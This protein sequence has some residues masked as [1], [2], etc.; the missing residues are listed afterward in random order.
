[1]ILWSLQHN[2][3][4]LECCWM[5]CVPWAETLHLT[6][7]WQRWGGGGK[8]DICLVAKSLGIFF[9]KRHNSPKTTSRQSR[10][11]LSEL[12]PAVGRCSPKSSIHSRWIPSQAA[13]SRDEVMKSFG[14]RRTDQST[15]DMIIFLS[16]LSRKSHCPTSELLY[17]DN[18]TVRT[19]HVLLSFLYVVWSLIL[20]KAYSYLDCH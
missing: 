5:M 14:T 2:L 6:P 20:F 3:S 1:M 9:N 8:N 19:C 10:E 7:V 18:A 17:L 4:R 12:V 13:S 16:T 11:S 15:F